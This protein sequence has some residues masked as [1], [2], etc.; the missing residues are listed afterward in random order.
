[1]AEDGDATARRLPLYWVILYATLWSI[2]HFGSGTLGLG[3]REVFR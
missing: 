2:N 1:M 3:I